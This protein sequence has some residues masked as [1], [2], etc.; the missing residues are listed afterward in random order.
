MEKVERFLGIPHYI[1]TNNF[2]YNKEKGFYC[3]KS[4]CQ[5]SYCLPK[6]KG[7]PKPDVDPKVEERRRAYFRPLNEDFFRMVN[8]TF[9]W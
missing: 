3:F 6:S 2:E 9:N 4:F 8:K 5:E 1:T 7:R